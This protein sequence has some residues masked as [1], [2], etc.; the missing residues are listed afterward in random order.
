MKKFALAIFCGMIIV[1]CA[2]TT[3]R[4]DYGGNKM[5]SNAEYEKMDPNVRWKA[6]FDNGCPIINFY[7]EF[8]KYDE[9]VD[10]SIT[11]QINEKKFLVLQISKES[12]C[13]YSGTGVVYKKNTPASSTNEVSA[14]NLPVNVNVSSSSLENLSSSFEISSSSFENDSSSVESL[15]NSSASEENVEDRLDEITKKYQ[16]PTS[17]VVSSSSSAVSAKQI[18]P[19]EREKMKDIS[20]KYQKA[21]MNKKNASMQ[22]QSADD[23]SAHGNDSNPK[24][25]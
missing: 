5:R 14:P 21:M 15:V 22:E 24:R 16:I 9:I 25:N 13:S 4:N 17:N 19:E 7:E 18:S 6:T 3:Y 10:V 2:S 20:K 23:L 12:V 8:P 1:G 11:E